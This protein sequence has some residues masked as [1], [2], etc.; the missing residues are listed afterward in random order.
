M[1]RRQV[2][3]QHGQCGVHRLLGRDILDEHGRDAGGDVSFVPDQHVLRGVGVGV[4]AVP[5]ERGVSGGE[6][7]A[8]ILL[9]PEWICACGGLVHVPDL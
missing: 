8:R 2:Q 6:C 7:F 3:N 5:G 9:L 1:C 4:P